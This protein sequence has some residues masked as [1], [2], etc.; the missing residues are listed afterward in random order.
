M[1]RDLQSAGGGGFFLKKRAEFVI[2][3]GGVKREK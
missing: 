1:G 2:G 3:E